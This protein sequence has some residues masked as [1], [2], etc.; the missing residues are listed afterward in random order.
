MDRMEPNDR[1]LIGGF[2]TFESI[3]KHLVAEYDETVPDTTRQ[4]LAMLQPRLADLQN[5]SN[6]FAHNLG[7]DLDPSIFWG[8]LGLILAVREP[9]FE[10]DSLD[11]SRDLTSQTGGLAT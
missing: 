11:Y 2:K 1:R 8:L 5:F 6:F 7:L 10:I 3:E 4:E 9:R